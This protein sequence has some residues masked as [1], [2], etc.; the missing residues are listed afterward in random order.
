[1]GSKGSS[2]TTTQ[3][4]TYT[5]NA[6]AM[7]AYQG[8]LQRAQGVAGQPYIPYGGELV[9][10]VNN[11]QNMG[12]GGINANANWAQPY[13]QGAIGQAQ[14]SSAPLSSAAIQSYMNPYTQSVVDA[15][16][17]Q[18]NNQ[19][20]QAL[21]QSRGQAIS[22]GALGGNRQ[23]IAEAE[24]QGQQQRAQA[25]IIAGLYSQGYNQA[26]NTAQQQQ[27]LGLQGA[28]LV[29][30]LGVAGQGTGLQGAQA[31]IGAGTLQQNTQQAL[32]TARLQQ[33][34]QQQAFPYQQLGWLSGIASG[35]GS[36]MGGT[37]YG[38]TTGPSPNPWSQALG[39]ITSGVG[40]LGA[41]GAFGSGGWMA[42]ALPALA[43]SDE[44]AKENIKSIGKTHDGQTIYRFNYKGEPQTHVGLLAQEVEQHK[45]EA[46]HQAQGV[47]YVDYDAATADS[48]KGKAEGGSMGMSGAA[49]STP[50]GGGLSFIPEV[51]IQ[52]GNTKLQ[53]PSV[54]RGNDQQGEL[55]KQA[56]S[57][58]DLAKTL[59]SSLSDAGPAPQDYGTSIP[60]A[61]GPTS[62]GGALGPAPIIDPTTQPM[63]RGGVV[64]GYSD[65]GTPSFDE[66]FNNAIGDLA[67]AGSIPRF[68][69][70][71]TQN[72]RDDTDRDMGRKDV[73]IPEKA[74]EA[75]GVVAPTPSNRMAFNVE[76]DNGASDD[77]PS[78]VTQGYS[79]APRSA[80]VSGASMATAQAPAERQGIDW[81]E[82]GKL[83]PSLIAAG[84]G[85]MAS[86]SP[87]LGNAVGEGLQHGAGA[88]N[89]ERQREAQAAKLA[90]DLQL[91]R[92]EMAQHKELA[93][94][95]YKGLTAAQRKN[96]ELHE[97][98]E[99]RNA[100]QPVDI[101]YDALGRAIKAIR[102]PDGSFRIIDP[103]S[104][105]LL[106]PGEDLMGG[107][108]LKSAP[109]SSPATNN[110]PGPSA[111][112]RVVQAN[113]LL[114]DPKLPGYMK[115]ANQEPARDE[116]VL[117][118]IRNL[119]G[120]DRVESIVKGLVS[121][122]ID[123]AK[124]SNTKGARDNYIA[125]A[126]MY[127]PS[128]DQAMYNAKAAGIKE[129]FAGGP[130]SPAGTMTAGNTAI[131]HLG[132]MYD[133][134]GKMEKNA[135]EA[136]YGVG[137]ANWIGKQG[138]PFIS[139]WA[140]QARNKA[141][142]GTGTE[143]AKNMADWQVAKTRF[144]DEVTK[145]YAGSGGS[146]GE[147][148]RALKVLD[149]AK[150][151][152]ELR[153]AIK[154]DLI[155]MRDKVEQMQGRLNTAIS[156]G[157]WKDIA[158]KDPSLILLYKNSRDISDKVLSGAHDA[159]S[160]APK[161]TEKPAAAAKP[162]LQEFL[163]KAKQANPNASDETLT[164]YYNKKY[165]G[166]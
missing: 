51:Q 150:S 61:V 121:Y 69:P 142:E 90:Q 132:E 110:A 37:T 96:V 1:M 101:G 127:D 83:W 125:M 118:R 65:G 17:A 56:A 164:Q 135:D 4:S 124:L 106:Q 141:A 166:Q 89:L 40:L 63:A 36:Q 137:A 64:R 130:Q 115:V 99:R 87:F 32:D 107:N 52:H 72:W 73:E 18:F 55:N 86:R 54:P 84:A 105:R 157:I 139:Y 122:D 156:P 148:E 88:Y 53:L 13:I 23:A 77:L 119:P 85:M 80:G 31:Q 30:N 11:Q 38:T 46:V 70:V 7:A 161:P 116:S 113:A 140:N 153:S 27:A 165:G 117:E 93:E 22:Q 133:L 146:E 58:G 158:K 95:P 47:K 19:N 41:T 109:A 24:L 20:K 151:P 48:V 138:V 145:F 162:S 42:S 78:E 152:A 62:V 75:K 25:P 76:R 33:W 6:D 3:Q 50:Y 74:I 2:N 144:A 102:S 111:A 39:G 60:G 112:P 92:E 149:E 136:G 79:R 5:P 147:R 21:Q 155:L 28:G 67:D 43:L 45:P 15:T 103:T 71:A 81:S 35:I 8:I 9:A 49:S 159:P 26:L 104:G 97:A 160:T 34:Q 134:V 16:Q 143:F 14:N 114:E 154:Q 129:F 68:D 163:A 57:I 29:G 120:G 10:G 108:P 59:R 131:L 100:M 128:Y 91:K 94:M 123:P 98:Q 82:N 126:K 66:R 12:I 44:R